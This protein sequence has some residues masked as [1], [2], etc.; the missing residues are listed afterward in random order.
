MEKE[1]AEMKKP[2]QP[3]ILPILNSYL[4]IYPHESGRFGILEEQ[5]SIGDVLIGDSNIRGHVTGSMFTL[6]PDKS[7]M[8]MVKHKVIKRWFQ[9][10]GHWDE[11]E[12]GPWV[13]AKRELKEETGIDDISSIPVSIEDSRIPFDIDSHL[14]PDN[15]AKNK[16]AHWH[17]DFRYLCVASRLKKL[18]HNQNE[19]DGIA[20]VPLGDE[21]LTGYRRVVGKIINLST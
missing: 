8:V 15:T 7:S 6:S 19:S 17:H 12:A 2:T 13:A 18:T 16:P 9:P 4:E 21:L 14:I 5:L 1:I 10:G 11:G 3:D 20:W